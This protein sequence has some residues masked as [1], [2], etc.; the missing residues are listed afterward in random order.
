[1]W[2]AIEMV[3]GELTRPFSVVLFQMAMLTLQGLR[4]QTRSED[5]MANKL[6][7]P[8]SP[9]NGASKPAVTIRD[10]AKAANVSVATVSNV[11]NHSNLV[12]SETQAKVEQAIKELGFVRHV[13][14]A[15]MRGGRGRTVGL[16]VRDLAMPFFT[17][18]AQGAEA[19][20]REQ[21]YLVILCNSNEDSEQEQRYFEVL[22]SQ[23]V[24][25]ILLSTVSEEFA[26]LDALH[27]RGTAVVLLGTTRT[28]YCSVRSDDR[29]GGELAAKHLVDLGHSNVAFIGPSHVF[30]PYRERFEGAQQYIHT[31]L[32]DGTVLELL[33]TTDA[34]D[35][36]DG[37]L[38]ADTLLDELPGVTAVLCGSD[39]IAIGLIAG[40]SRRGIRVPEDISVVGYD[41]I[42]LATQNFVPLTTVSQPMHNI[43]RTAARMLFEE[44][45]VGIHHS[46][47]QATFQPQL[48][49]RSSTAVARSGRAG[50]SA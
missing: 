31:A 1:M 40:L 46:H 34:S 16:V 24:T 14:A 13:G 20:A 22:E 9:E 17:E 23:R 2:A 39:L 25:G 47:Q 26:N 29:A 6:E 19:A 3:L 7:A 42:Q 44:A 41:N 5:S 49:V 33:T 15:L 4:C 36:E 45:D 21:D 27:D 48:V 43:G 35:A 12:A 38:A 32:G 8:N 50:A 37:Q 11:L 18:L 10:V 30:R 28:G